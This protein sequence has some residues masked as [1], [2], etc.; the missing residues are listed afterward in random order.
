MG[1]ESVIKNG[2]RKIVIHKIGEHL[3]NAFHWKLEGR[4]NEEISERLRALKVIIYKQK[5]SMIFSNP[6]YC[7][8][9]LHKN[10]KTIYDERAKNITDEK[11]DLEVNLKEI[12][13][14]LDKLGEK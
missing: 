3:S 7:D 11:N 10:I 9:P 8:V 13:K 2:E 1:Y 5:L 4:K 14:H 12:Q 6:Y